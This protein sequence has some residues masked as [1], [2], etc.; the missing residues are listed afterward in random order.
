M[1]PNLRNRLISATIVA[2]MAFM[3]V[4]FFPSVGT[5]QDSGDYYAVSGIRFNNGKP[6]GLFGV[7]RRYSENFALFI[8]SDVGGEEYSLGGAP[9]VYF[10]MSSRIFIGALIGPQLETIDENP[11]YEKAISYLT[12]TTGLLIMYKFKPSAGL[13]AGF[14]YLYTD[15]DIKPVKFGIGFIA[16]L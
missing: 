5:C 9:I 4:S 13:W 8:N 10:E 2:V 12:A 14:N 6:F 1:N 16:G 3:G 15:A 11:D 7:L